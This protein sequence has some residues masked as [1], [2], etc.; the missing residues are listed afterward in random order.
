MRQIPKNDRRA[1]AKKM[2]QPT[3]SQKLQYMERKRELIKLSTIARKM[4]EES[5]HEELPLNHF[6]MQLY[7]AERPGVYNT[8]HEWKELG[9]YVKK[10]EKGT[11]VWGVPVKATKRE[12]VEGQSIEEEME[13]FPLCYLF[14]ESQVEEKATVKQKQPAEA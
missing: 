8:F 7:Q 2:K 6:I 3:E 12:M 1:A 11:P 10:G 9:K 13:F 4:R 14:H 5:K